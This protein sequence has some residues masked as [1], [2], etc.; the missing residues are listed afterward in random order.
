M[1]HSFDEIDKMSLS[2][3]GDVIGYW[4]EKERGDNKLNEQRQGKKR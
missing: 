4:S 2:D 3:F 1:G